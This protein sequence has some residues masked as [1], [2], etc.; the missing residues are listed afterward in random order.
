MILEKFSDLITFLAS[1]NGTCDE[2]LAKRVKEGELTSDEAVYVGV[3]AKMRRMRNEIARLE[4]KTDSL[5]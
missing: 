3:Y 2:E 1:C 5:L 4:S